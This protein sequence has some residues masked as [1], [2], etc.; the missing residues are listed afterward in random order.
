MPEFKASVQVMLKKSILDP[1]G[2]TVENTLS[3]LGHTNI[4]DLRIGKIIDLTLS[5]ER[6]EVEA[7]LADISKS[8]LS[9]PVME[10]VTYTLQELEPA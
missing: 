1:Q 6:A 8:I 7:Q 9:N 3:R 2:R 4:S 10:D 5:G